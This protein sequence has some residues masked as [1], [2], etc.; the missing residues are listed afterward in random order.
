M[1]DVPEQ[2]AQ[3]SARRTAPAFPWRVAALVVGD[4]VSFLVF[5]GIGRNQHGETSGLGALLE[6]AL[7]AA[8]FALGWFLVSPW[9]GA[10]RRKLTTGVGR[11]LA[12]TELAWLAAF[13]VALVL[14]LVLDPQHLSLGQIAAFAAVIL[15]VNALFLGVWRGAFALVAA[16]WA[17]RG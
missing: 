15:C 6:I 17:R 13:P 5:A 11:M 2:A 7:T 9:L 3:G 4:A 16:W 1:A 14:R 10:F 8:P 12:R